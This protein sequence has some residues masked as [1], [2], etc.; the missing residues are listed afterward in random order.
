MFEGNGSIFVDV[1]FQTASAFQFF[2]FS[3][4]TGIAY[5]VDIA[6]PWTDLG[7]DPVPGREIGFRVSANDNDL[8]FA[9]QEVM[10][11]NAADSTLFDTTSWDTLVLDRRSSRVRRCPLN[12]LRLQV[13]LL[14]VSALPG[15]ASP[16]AGATGGSGATSREENLPG[17]V[18]IVGGSHGK[19]GKSGDASVEAGQRLGHHGRRKLWILSLDVGQGGSCGYEIRLWPSR[20]WLGKGRGELGRAV[21][22]IAAIRPAASIRRSLQ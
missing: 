1:P 14:R 8:G 7:I 17:D 12:R 13:S 10:Y 2:D 20:S 21:P 3:D 5:T 19:A 18:E 11:T 15:A 6:I 9:N 4:E 16:A 22:W